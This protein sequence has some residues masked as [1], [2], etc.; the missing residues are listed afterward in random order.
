[1]KYV[2]YTAIL[3][4]RD[5]LK[6][7]LVITPNTDYVCFT[8]NPPQHKSAWRFIDPVA[9]SSDPVVSARMHKICGLGLFPEYA[10][11]L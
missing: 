8:D 10:S 7:P 1:M 9:Y 6:E 4:G 2:V 11:S 5:E 3:A